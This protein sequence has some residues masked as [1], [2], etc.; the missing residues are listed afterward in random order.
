VTLD[1]TFI[2]SCLRLSAAA[3]LHLGVKKLVDNGLQ[4]SGA[5]MSERSQQSSGLAQFG[6][7]AVTRYL[8][9]SAL[10][11]HLPAIHH[12]LR[13]PLVHP[14][15]LYRELL[16]FAG[17]LLVFGPDWRL[18]DFPTYAHG[19]LR[20][21]YA[22]LLKLIDQL[23]AATVPTGYKL[24]PLSKTSP[25]Q[26]LANLK[27]VDF[28][29]VKQ[30]FLGVSAQASEVDILTAVQR[31]AKMAPAAHL[32]TLVSRALPGLALVP[33]TQPPS[34]MPVK[35]GFKYFRLHQSGDLWN[36]VAG[37]KSLAIH[38]PGDLPATRLELLATLEN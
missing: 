25:I 12:F 19:D 27:E 13:H 22:P 29:K 28:S 34:G 31:K 20:G 5:L 38:M 36:Q 26:Y 16:G 15:I 9:L 37:T 30:V 6:A 11:R 17:S 2:P 10:N 33:E 32:E 14:E 3:N 18:A 23:L 1:E 35:A 4:K 7:E 8:L 24:I 21:C